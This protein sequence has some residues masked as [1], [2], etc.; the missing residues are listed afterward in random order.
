MA[1]RGTLDLEA[2]RHAIAEVLSREGA[3]HL[4]DAARRWKVHPMTIRRDFDHLV[5]TG[6]AR[7]VRAGIIALSGDDFAE[8]RHQNAEAKRVIAEKLRGLVGRGDVLALDASTTITAFAERMPDDELT[9]VTNGLS[10]FR[11]LAS[12]PGM[13][14]YLTGG[15]QDEHNQSLVGSL[16]V[17]AVQQFAVDTAFLSAMSVD[18]NFGTSEMTLEQ[19]A[20]KKAVATVADRCVLGVDSSKLESKARFR[21]LALPRF[22]VLVTE[23]DPGD[24]RLDPY[25]GHIG[26]IR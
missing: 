18:E 24:T 13:R 2:R 3:V 19:V 22:D 16:A 20:F 4:Q 1:V 9:V 26:L 7:R 14:S 10:A 12:R 5:S 15:E 17:L 21:S 23:L 6:M 25:R 11:T 8:R